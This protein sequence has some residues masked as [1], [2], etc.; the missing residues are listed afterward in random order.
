VLAGLGEAALAAG[1]GMALAGRARGALR[2][3]ARS[4]LG[5]LVRGRFDGQLPAY[6]G[7]RALAHAGR[8]GAAR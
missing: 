7:H 4:Q 5:R 3:A 6:L 8:P 1:A 2:R